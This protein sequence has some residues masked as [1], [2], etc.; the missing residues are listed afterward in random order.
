[1]IK[2]NAS[3]EVNASR[4][5]RLAMTNGTEANKS[6]TKSVEPNSTRPVRVN[7]YLEMDASRSERLITRK[8]TGVITT[9]WTGVEAKCRR[10]LF[11]ACIELC[12]FTRFLL[13]SYSAIFSSFIW[14]VDWF[15]FLIQRGVPIF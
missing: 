10:K 8:Q 5:E 13:I 2:V 7:A 12:I 11:R 14:L 15:Y 9:R 4:P 6:T 1:M 3:A